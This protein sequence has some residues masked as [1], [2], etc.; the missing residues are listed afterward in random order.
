MRFPKEHR[1]LLP[2]YRDTTLLIHCRFFPAAEINEL[3]RRNRW[4][5]LVLFDA[6]AKKLL[7]SPVKVDGAVFAK[8]DGRW[9]HKKL[10]FAVKR[11]TEYLRRKF[12]KKC[13]KKAADAVILNLDKMLFLREEI[14]GKAKEQLKSALEKWPSKVAK[15]PC[16][17]FLCSVFHRKN[18]FL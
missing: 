18:F 14:V 2:Q 7:A 11:Y 4:V 6:S 3:Q 9:D 10:N 5:S 1:R 16:F 12:E 15:A 8:S 13:W 17:L